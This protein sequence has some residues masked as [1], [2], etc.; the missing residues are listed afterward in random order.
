MPSCAHCDTSGGCLWTRCNCCGQDIHSACSDDGKCRSQSQN[1]IGNTSIVQ[2]LPAPESP[3]LITRDLIEAMI[4]PS[5]GPVKSWEIETGPDGSRRLK[6]T[7]YP[8]S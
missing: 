2:V 8:P 6:V 3:H 5:V 1:D 7:F 4:G